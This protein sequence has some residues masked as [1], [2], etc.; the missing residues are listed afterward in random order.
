M[1][2]LNVIFITIAKA[3]NKVLLQ[4]FEKTSAKENQK[5]FLTLTRAKYSK[6]SM[7]LFMRHGDDIQLFLQHVYNE[8]S[9][10][11]KF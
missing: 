1:F 4:S 3:T 7:F 6:M 8:C 10:V 2:Q 9:E 5:M 11:H